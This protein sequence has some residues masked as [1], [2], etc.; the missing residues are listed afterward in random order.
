MIQKISAA[1]L[2]VLLVMVVQE[3]LLYPGVLSWYSFK[4]PFLKST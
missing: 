3:A 2:T 1:L 4:L